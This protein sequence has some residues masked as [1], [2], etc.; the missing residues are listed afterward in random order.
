MRGAGRRIRAALGFL[1]V[2][3]VGTVEPL[4]DDLGRAF[5]PAAGL[6]L[7]GLAWT[8]LLAVSLVATPLLGAVAAV[9][10]LVGLSG[11]L[12]LD[13]LADAADGL[14]GG[15]TRERRLEIMRDPRVGSFG[16]AA[17]ALVLLGDVAALAGLDRWRALPALLAA[18]ALSRLGML[19]MVL[20]LPYARGRGGLGA[21][22]QGGGRL[23]A[24]AVAVPVAA[25][26]VAL[27]W[28]HGLLA[29]ALAGAVAVGIGALARARIGGATGDVYGAVTEVGQLAALVAYA[30]RL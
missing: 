5:F 4:P 15:S 26:P 20:A 29:A 10:A 9:A 8:A 1:T 18:G 7:G 13:G 12:H 25:L 6:L 24:L 3:P 11:A 16:V 19:G 28:R 23:P 2:L 22:V 17:I 21:L 14:L 27:D 30:V